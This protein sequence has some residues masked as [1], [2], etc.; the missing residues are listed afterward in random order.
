MVEE[1]FIIVKE[2]KITR[3]YAK[4]ALI[5]SVGLV[6]FIAAC[7]MFVL[8]WSF[9]HG[10]TAPAWA[11]AAETSVITAALALIFKDRSSSND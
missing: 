3:T 7:G 5:L 4:W 2:E 1:D 9:F 6:G 11:L 8:M 10:M